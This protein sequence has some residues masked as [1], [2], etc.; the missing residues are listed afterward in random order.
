MVNRVDAALSCQTVAKTFTDT[1]K[2]AGQMK[3]KA[4]AIGKRTSTADITLTWASPQDRFSVTK[5]SLKPKRGARISIS[6]KHI[7]RTS[8]K[9]Y[10]NVS[11]KGLKPGKLYFKLKVKKLG[12]ATFGGV[13]LTTQAVPN[14]RR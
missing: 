7:K 8:G 9:T 2:K 3:S 12:P 5:I 11:V 10:L 1:F 6:K 4:I 14:K 13:T